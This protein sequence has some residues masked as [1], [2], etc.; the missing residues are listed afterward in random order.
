MD[1]PSD[2]SR[3]W[4]HLLQNM[5]DSPGIGKVPLRRTESN[6][7]VAF[8]QVIQKGRGEGKLVLPDRGAVPPPSIRLPRPRYSKLLFDPN[9]ATLHGAT[10]DL[11]TWRLGVRL[12]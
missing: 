6:R 10:Q 5:L 11:S 9:L 4:L 2:A 12:S 3:H 8:A 7:D 1:E